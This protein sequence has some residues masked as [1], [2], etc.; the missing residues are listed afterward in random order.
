MNLE[1]IREA[2]RRQP[3]CSFTLRLAD[4]RAIEFDHP[5]FIALTSR[6]VV[7]TNAMTDAVSFLEPLLIVSLEYARAIPAADGESKQGGD[8]A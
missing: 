4:G 8:A 2:I 5:E 3:F 7:V 6:V 1:P